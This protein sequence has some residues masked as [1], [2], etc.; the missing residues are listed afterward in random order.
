MMLGEEMWVT[1]EGRAPIGAAMNNKEK[2][3]NELAA[4]MT[5]EELCEVHMKFESLDGGYGGSR[6]ACDF[7]GKILRKR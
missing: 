4:Q 6:L 1:D 3:I 7:I 5:E 2:E